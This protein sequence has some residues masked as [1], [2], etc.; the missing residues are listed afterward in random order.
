ML[1]KKEAVMCG[2]IKVFMHIFAGICILIM[3]SFYIR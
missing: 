3:I 1:N 2:F